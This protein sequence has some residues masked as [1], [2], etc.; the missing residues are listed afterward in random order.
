[1]RC[2]YCGHTENKVIDSRESK[3]GDS[4]RRRREC[5]NCQKRFTTYETVVEIELI[6]IKKNGTREP[7]SREKLLTCIQKAC[8]KRPISI[9]T[10][11]HEANEVLCSLMSKYEREVSSTDI[12]EMV[13]ERLKMIDKVAYV[14]F[15]SVYRQFK[16]IDEFMSEL[17]T[18]LK[19]LSRKSKTNTD[20]ESQGK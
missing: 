19:P 17:Q 2:P 9:E 13:M 3:E 15:A 14:R 7:F 18:L 10:I 8:V 12:G 20:K 1:M 6:V 5:L 16:E 4:I 11:E